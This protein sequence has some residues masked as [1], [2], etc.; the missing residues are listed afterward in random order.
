MAQKIA[1]ELEF[2]SSGAVKNIDQVSK[3]IQEVNTAA[4][5]G[6]KEVS[7]LSK[8]M[9]KLGST[10]KA[11]A[12]GG[13]KAVGSAIKGIGK[14]YMAAGIG[15]MVAG[16]GFL[17]NAFKENQKVI[18][19]FNIVMDV[20][21]SIGKQVSDVILSVYK[22]VSSA[23]ENFDALGKVVKGLLTLAIT[24]LKLGFQAIKGALLGAQL[25]WEQSWLG[26][27][28]PKRIEELKAELSEVK[29]SV[30]EIGT[31][32]VNAGKSI[33][34]NFSE[35]IAEAGSIATQVVEGVK[36]ISIEAA[37]ETATTNV[38]LKKSADRAR[39]ANQGLIEKYDRQ[40]E[41]QRQIRDN[42]FKTIAQRT[43]ANEKLKATLEEQK[44]LMLE[45]VAAIQASAQAQFDLTGK[46]ED[47]L[48]LLE[49]KN[50]VKAVEAQIE[51]FMSEQDS[52][53]NALLKEKIEL[54]QA[55][56]DGL[57]EREVIE[58][59]FALSQMENEFARLEAQKAILEA[60]L[61][62]ETQRLT[63]KRDLYQQGTQ[64]YIDANNE[65][66][67]YQQANSNQQVEIDKKLQKTKSEL[68]TQALKDLVTIVGK[69]SKFGKAIAI[70]QAIRDTYA[71]ATKALAQ[72]GIFGFIGAAAVTAAGIAN[73]KS[74]LSTKEPQPPAGLGA[75]G[76][77]AV[78]TPALP[79]PPTFNTV[80]ASDTNQ[81]AGVIGDQSKVPTK[82]YVVSGDVTTAQSLDR[83]IIEGATI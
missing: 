43:E 10:G 81:L 31:D 58:D 78:P 30:I 9:K 19:Q 15:L 57:R 7:V 36:K 32:A 69:N 80:G 8:G 65:L 12:K 38:E 33:V 34:N 17:F 24:P 77:G 26:G 76:G 53:R 29:D 41:Q 25:A 28:D 51:G 11:I 70:V 49:A 61:I 37:V 66:L 23:T 72:G 42:E 6:V 4:D 5:K 39:I 35:A 21:A 2:D 16:F 74:I 73:V 62:L 27:N 40:A 59:E 64:A 55:Q 13:L 67:A 45:N 22:N 52:N 47:Y 79:T 50:E 44:T 3:G 75:S 18:D 68:V 46:E 20:L 48:A 14:A 56:R 1:I 60:E 83:N 63:E 82:A 54:E 71:G